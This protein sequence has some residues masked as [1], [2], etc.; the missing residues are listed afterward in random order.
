MSEPA[1]GNA[2]SRSPLVVVF[3][4]VFIDLL[5]FGII[6]PLLPVYS[7]AYGATEPQLGLLF[8]SFS[9]MQLVFSSMWG[10]MS[11]RIGRR[12]VLLGGLVGT[13]AS[14]ALFAVS[15]SLPLL[16]ASRVLAGF[17]G[18][19][20]STAQAYIA[21]VT[22]PENRARGMGL[23]G[24]AFGL[25]FTVGPLVGGEL[26]K[27]WMPLPGLVAAALSLAAAAFGWRNLVEPTRHEAT[28]ASRGLVEMK[29]AFSTPRSGTLYVLY[30]LA[31]FA[32]TAFESMF[33]RF[34]LARFPSIF[35][36]ATDAR[37]AT[38][39]EVLRAAPIAGRYLA[40]IGIFSALVQGGLIRRLVKKYGETRLAVVG[41]FLLGVALLIIGGATF[42]PASS[43]AQWWIVLVGCALM[44]FGFGLNNPSLNGL[45]SRAAP[46]GNQ[47]TYL[48]L[49]QAVASGARTVG[50]PMAG[51]V[52][53][54]LGP[55]SPF[56]L[57][58]CAL[59]V[60]TFISVG[61]RSRFASTFTLDGA[62]SAPA[63][64]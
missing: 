25:G 30:F 31:I 56:F 26:S 12:P 10:R 11:D 43:T 22:T 52:F 64:H 41:P 44:P 19:N 23:I 35:G 36:L 40:A 45:V 13:A 34:G 37:R 48:G 29:A 28:T 4:T 54:F 8:G 47:G 7:K 60:A 16:F 62:T 5:G 9:L 57:G 38:V 24:A 27:V 42:V 46:A 3:L 18:A 1:T 50:P 20:V 51:L 49:M 58:A 14:Y 63:G 15:N 39:D 17:F 32:F 33:T 6:I 59:A 21:D 53:A 55:E 61:Y 2:K